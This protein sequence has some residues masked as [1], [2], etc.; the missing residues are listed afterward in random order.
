M[1]MGPAP[2]GFVAVVLLLP[3]LFSIPPEEQLG[4]IEPDN[5]HWQAPE[6]TYYAE[7]LLTPYGTSIAAVDAYFRRK[8]ASGLSGTASILNFAMAGT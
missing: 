3:Y 6:V 1:N 8:A 4:F 5:P 2:A 7:E